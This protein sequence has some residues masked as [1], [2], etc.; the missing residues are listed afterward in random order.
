MP[1]ALFWER[2]A[3]D[4]RS[5][6]KTLKVPSAGLQEQPCHRIWVKWF[7]SGWCQEALVGEQGDEAGKGRKLIQR[8]D[9]WVTCM[10]NCGHH[11]LHAGEEIN[12]VVKSMSQGFTSLGWEGWEIYPLTLIHYWVRVA[13]E[14]VP[15][16]PAKHLLWAEKACSSPRWLQKEDGHVLNGKNTR[17]MGGVL[18]L[19]YRQ[20]YAIC[21]PVHPK[22]HL[23]CG[24]LQGNHCRIIDDSTEIHCCNYK[25]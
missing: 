4:V 5:G 1:L 2:C 7:I 6:I 20:H 19:S 8:M 11:G 21:L 3:D 17:T 16:L 18:T 23:G 25:F 9:E 24:W 12:N 13:L 14:A 10:A 15:S 22:G